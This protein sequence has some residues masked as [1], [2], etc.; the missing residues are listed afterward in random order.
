MDLVEEEDRALAAVAEPLARP[1]DDGAHLRLAGLDGGE[2]L[3][4]GARRARHDPCEGRLAGA[5]RAEQD[6]RAD[7]VLLDR[8]AQR[9]A[10][11]DHPLLADE[12][13]ERAG[14][15]PLGERRLRREA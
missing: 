8:A 6:Q 10:R 9:R 11:P 12:V 2:L 15:Q 14:A 7:A 5:R 1:L 4:R 3:E 13:V